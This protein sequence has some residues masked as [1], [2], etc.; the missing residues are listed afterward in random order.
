[1]TCSGPLRHS[2]PSLALSE[3]RAVAKLGVSA[4]P[5]R[6]QPLSVLVLFTMFLY[7]NLLLF[8]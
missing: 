5:P 8:T 4:A 6:F 7:T 1:M 2:S 3:T